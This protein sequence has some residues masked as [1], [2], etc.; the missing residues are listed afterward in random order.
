MCQWFAPTTLKIT[1]EREGKGRVTE[2]EAEKLVI[3]NKKG[4]VERLNLPTKFV[5][6][7]NHQVSVVFHSL[8]FRL[9]YPVSSSRFTQTGGMHGACCTLL[10]RVA[11]IVIYISL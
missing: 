11:S 10:D 4:Q 6:I 2:E 3:R 8:S 9:S 7:S 5:L 1:F